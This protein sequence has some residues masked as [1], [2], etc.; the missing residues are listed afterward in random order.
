VHPPLRKRIERPLAARAA[1]IGAVTVRERSI[2]K[3]A[4]A[5]YAEGRRSRV[6]NS[7]TPSRLSAILRKWAAVIASYT[8]EEYLTS[9]GVEM[10]S[11][12][13]LRPL[14]SQETNG[15]ESTARG[16][17]FIASN[18]TVESGAT[19]RERP[20]LLETAFVSDSR[21]TAAGKEVARAVRRRHWIVAK[22]V[23]ARRADG[24]SY[25]R[26]IL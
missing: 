14:P 15:K 12:R 7:S 26:C 5:S 3:Y 6:G 2:L 18:G 9:L 19:R 17:H 10:P 20:P 1:P 8:S 21:P 25:V 22:A 11:A 23:T 24:V 13:E 16:W 4:T